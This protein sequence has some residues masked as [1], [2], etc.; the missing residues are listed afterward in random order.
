MGGP[1]FRP[2]TG[3]AFYKSFGYIYPNT[4]LLE[5]SGLLSALYFLFYGE[6]A[7][8]VEYRYFD[9]LGTPTCGVVF[10]LLSGVLC[11]VTHFDRRNSVKRKN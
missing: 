10:S 5:R 1:N 6:G 7:L 2:S 11:Q 8:R 9:G 4:S 3:E